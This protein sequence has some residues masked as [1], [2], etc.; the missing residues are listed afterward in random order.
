MRTLPQ[1]LCFTALLLSAAA[2]LA[3]T[4]EKRVD[5]DPRGELEI[6]N[7]A[8]KVRVTGWDRPE[9]HVRAELGRGVEKVDVERDGN[10]VVVKVRLPSGRSSGGTDLYIDAPLGSSVVTSTV[11]ADQELDNMRS[12]QR[13]QSVSGNIHTDVYGGD[14]QA[15]TVSGDIDASGRG[16]ERDKLGEARVSSVSGNIV[17]KNLGREI[18]MTTVSGDIRVDS[19]DVSRLHV[20]STNGEVDFTGALLADGRIEAEAVNGDLSFN[21]LGTVNAEFDIETFN[22][23]IDN[24][25][26]QKSRRTHEHGPGNELRFKEGDGRSRVRLKTLNGDVNVCKR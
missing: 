26:G 14:F 19:P 21:F 23:D 5:A 11:S 4:V 12:G 13:L 15:K 10:R 3:E 7:V 6:S 20:K 8:G 16:K 9:V 24:C 25:F 1:T 18:E 22:G 2:A 17:I